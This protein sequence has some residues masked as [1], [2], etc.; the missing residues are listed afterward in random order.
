MS[1]STKPPPARHS[2]DSP[3]LGLIAAARGYVSRRFAL[4]TLTLAIGL[5]ALSRPT[6]IMAS[7]LEAVPERE[8]DVV[9]HLALRGSG[10]HQTYR[11][12]PFEVPDGVRAITV[13]ISFTG[14][15]QRATID[16]G[17]EDP[18]RFRG[19]SGGNK[20]LISLSEAEATPSYLPGPI[21]PGTWQVLLG[22]PNLRGETESAVQARIWFERADGHSA[23]VA[24]SPR[25]HEIDEPRWYRG[26]LHAHSGHS[27][28]ACSSQ[29]GQRIPC[30]L[31]RTLAVAAERGLDFVSVTD[32]NTTSQFGTLAELRPY[33]DRLLII[34]GREITTFWGHANVFGVT[35][36][37]D[38]DLGSTPTQGLERLIDR[39]AGTSA[40]LSINHPLLP[41]GELCMGCG[42]TFQDTLYERFQAV[43]VINGGAMKSQRG[44]AEGPLSGIPFW[45]DRLAQGHALVAIAGSDNHDP[46]LPVDT[47]SAL[48]SLATVVYADRLSEPAILEGLR[49]GRVFV[50]VGDHPSLK[51]DF[52]VTAAN[53][54]GVAMG[55]SIEV[56]AGGAL[57]V[58]VRT[59]GARGLRL[60]LLGRS[61]GSKEGRPLRE[62]RYAQDFILAEL[63]I[64]TEEFAK[65]VTGLT[66][67][68]DREME[69]GGA[70]ET[71]WGW[72]RVELRD[73]DDHLVAL[74][75][76][77]RLIV[78]D[79]RPR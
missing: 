14:K 44:L 62:S 3:P 25:A 70:V 47:A 7:Q 12:L 41:S 50:D 40:L 61:V 55:G 77:V 66:V 71:A 45:L 65:E 68:S 79:A 56:S 34:P 10:D 29:S 11:R 16:L 60:V 15:E 6:L 42:W 37:V 32:H 1:D 72:V 54:H 64:P 22:V 2:F 73:E 13:E 18:Q 46:D 78:R 27:D 5:A 67:T 48:G 20:S 58:S 75:N 38:F 43:E 63:A 9:L 53:Q 59:E 26:D 30:P 35:D 49:S 23:F 17:L 39:L 28:G 74:S 4:A 52:T 31:F 24:T 69:T 21:D 76:A 33:F 51:V 36:F 19:W 57:Q 8:P